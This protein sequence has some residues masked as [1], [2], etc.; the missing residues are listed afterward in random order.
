MTHSKFESAVLMKDAS[1]QA[2]IK[3]D[4]DARQGQAFIS[5]SLASQ[6]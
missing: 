1:T 2:G 3:F 6:E 4:R 5:P